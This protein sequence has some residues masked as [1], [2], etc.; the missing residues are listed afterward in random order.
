MPALLCRSRARLAAR[1]FTFI[2]FPPFIVPSGEQIH[3]SDRGWWV[4]AWGWIGSICWPQ[5]LAWV[6]VWYHSQFLLVQSSYTSLLSLLGISPSTILE[7]GCGTIDDTWPQIFEKLWGMGELERRTWREMTSCEGEEPKVFQRLYSYFLLLEDLWLLE[8][9][10][11]CMFYQDT[12]K[13]QKVVDSC[14]A[15]YGS[16]KMI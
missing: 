1:R 13:F 2:A 9:F 7:K 6:L 3:Q 4:Y 8:P 12:A 16:C 14:T 11:S 10:T 5:H 15:L